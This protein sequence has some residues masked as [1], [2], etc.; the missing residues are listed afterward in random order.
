MCRVA[1]LF[2]IYR[3]HSHTI[4]SQRKSYSCISCVHFSAISITLCFIIIL[5]MI[6]FMSLIDNSNYCSRLNA[7]NQ[8]SSLPFISLITSTCL[9]FLFYSTHTRFSMMTIN[10]CEDYVVDF[11]Q[12]FTK[13]ILTH[14]HVTK[15]T[16]L[17]LK[18]DLLYFVK[19]NFSVFKFLMF[20][21]KAIPLAY[22]SRMSNFYILSNEQKSFMELKKRRKESN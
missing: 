3:Q 17:S 20:F 22:M 1:N 6:C 15:K 5:M 9:V 14:A 10:V 19:K 12:I 13:N 18:N 8:L 7:L 21:Q 2:L 4:L 11:M 16:V